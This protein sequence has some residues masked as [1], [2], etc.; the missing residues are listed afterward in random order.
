MAAPYTPDGS[1]GRAKRLTEPQITMLVQE[2]VEWMT[3]GQA[4]RTIITTL[5]SRGYTPSQVRTLLERAALEIKDQ[6][7]DGI[8]TIYERALN[9]L[10]MLYQ[11]CISKGNYKTAIEV[12][13]EIDRISGLHNNRLEIKAELR[14][15]EVIKITEVKKDEG[16]GNEGEPDIHEEL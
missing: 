3:I 6:Y 4:T 11:N 12:Q 1:S 8:S 2:V 16:T 10:E 13:K 7:K 14:I 15:P 9:R 5:T